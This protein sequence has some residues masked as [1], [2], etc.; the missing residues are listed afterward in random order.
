MTS[1]GIT[2]PDLRGKSVA[3]TGGARGLG[4]AMVEAFARNGC[5]VLLVDV[6]AAELERVQEHLSAE[7]PQQ[8]VSVAAVSV[9]EA[10]AVADA[11]ADFAERTGSLDVLVNNAG[12]SANVPS[13]DLDVDRWR[14]VIDVNLT[15]VFVCAQA[16][17]RI[18]R[19][20][21]AGV[22]LNISS[23]YGVV[24]AAERA[25]YCASK[26]AVAS[27]TKVLA[28]EWA[29]HGIRVNAIGPGYVETDL[30]SSLAEQGRLDLDVLRRRTPSGRLGSTGDIA[31]LALFLSSAA[32]ANITGQVVVSDG[33]WTAD[34]FGVA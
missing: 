12:I 8:T 21:G 2:C 26:A 1:D 16:A 33:G 17:G 28:V 34:G 20:Q 23:M 14:R 10:E 15:G 24:S 19:T 32:S 29:A 5:H 3:V 4:L 22:V 25:S 18:M 27:L 11:L 13:L 7:C 9:A 6:D 31:Q 30:L